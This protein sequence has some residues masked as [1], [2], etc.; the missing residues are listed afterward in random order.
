ML[1][2]PTCGDVLLVDDKA[3]MEYNSALSF[4]CQRCPYRHKLKASMHRD[5]KLTVKEVDDVL[6]GKEAWEN[7][8]KTEARCPSCDHDQAYFIQFQTRS[9]DEPMTTFY[10][11]CECGKQWKDNM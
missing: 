10:K 11:C 8:D 7:V 4:Y 5:T 6:G 1:F 9:A 3:K 2:C